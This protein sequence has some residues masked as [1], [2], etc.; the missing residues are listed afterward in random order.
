VRQ[1]VETLHLEEKV[2]LLSGSRR[3]WT[4]DMSVA[5]ARPLRCHPQ[6][7][8]GGFRTGSRKVI[9][10]WKATPGRDGCSTLKLS[11]ARP[12]HRKIKKTS[13]FS[14]GSAP[15]LFGSPRK[16][17]GL[18]PMPH[19]GACA[20]GWYFRG[21]RASHRRRGPYN[22]LNPFGQAVLERIPS[23]L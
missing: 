4:M 7:R 16:T 19:R 13:A 3:S 11:G 23:P 6:G 18:A 9:P 17:S 1:G 10:P 12:A 15:S 20:K 5:S 14:L 22:R 21:H 2:T 8:S